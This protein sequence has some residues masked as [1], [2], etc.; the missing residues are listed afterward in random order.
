MP[1]QTNLLSRLTWALATGVDVTALSALL[2]QFFGHDG[3]VAGVIALAVLLILVLTYLVFKS[4][5]VDRRPRLSGFSVLVALTILLVSYN[6]LVI[7]PVWPVEVAVIEP[8]DRAVA[9]SNQY[10]VKGTV[11]EPEATVYV[12]V[13]SLKTPETIWVQDL[14]TIDSAGNWQVNAYLGELEIGKGQDYEISA[15]ASDDSYL[16]KLLTG[17]IMKIGPRT[18]LPQNT[19]HSNFVTVTRVN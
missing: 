16:V 8:Q 7:R 6:L 5:L 14:P 4:G 9:T 3:V 17:T 18:D 12:L 19:N 10:L 2:A 1:E 11:S 13:R 15:I